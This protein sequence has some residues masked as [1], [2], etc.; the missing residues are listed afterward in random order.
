MAF[1]TERFDSSKFE[2]GVW[3]EVMGGRFKIAR[4]GNATYERI[5]AR[6]KLDRIKDPVRYQRELYRCI[7][8]GIVLDWDD[9]MAQGKP[10]PY[11]VESFVKVLQ[12][13]PDLL[14]PLM[15]EANDLENFRNEA[16]ESDLGE[17]SASSAG[18]TI[19]SRKTSK[20]PTTNTSS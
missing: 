1:E 11:S 13:N 5:R 17:P 12:R 6:A 16:I 7:G 3:V 15:D 2:E 4:A 9:V 10:I 8:E 14:A 20:T 19:G 18:V